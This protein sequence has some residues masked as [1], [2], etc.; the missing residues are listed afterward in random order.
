MLSGIVLALSV[1]S[2]SLPAYASSDI[3]IVMEGV[4]IAADVKPEVKN[5]RTMVPL[6]IISENLG[7]TVNWSGSEVTLAKRGRNVTIDLESGTTVID[8]T[9]MALDARPYARNNRTMVP[10]RFLAEALGSRVHYG[11][12]T[13]TVDTD[14]LVIDGVRV[15]ALQQEYHMTMGGVVNHVTGNAYIEAI[16]NVMTDNK[17]SKVEEPSD[18]TWSVHYTV[19]GGYYKSGQY[20]FLDEADRSLA[21]YDIYSLVTNMDA[22]SEYL[23]YDAGEDAWYSFDRAAS[24]SI[25]RFIDTAAANGFL[26]MIYN[27]VP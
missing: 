6:R 5:N 19:P 9:K 17:G 18:Y 4:E 2:A 13:V 27:D 23:I 8:G 16:Y 3:R 21:R 25:Y 26:K 11:N 14:P 12:S 24:Q 20:D 15:K 7:A 10:L 1:A 22:A